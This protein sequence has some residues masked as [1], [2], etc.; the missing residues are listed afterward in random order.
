MKVLGT[1]IRVFIE[2]DAMDKT[3]KFY[4][5]LYQTTCTERGYNDAWK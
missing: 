1:L 5:K 3:I 4:E 2:R